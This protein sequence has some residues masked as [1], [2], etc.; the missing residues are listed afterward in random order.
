MLPRQAVLLPRVVDELRQRVREQPIDGRGDA[1][2][3]ALVAPPP[4]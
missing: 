4:R 1:D 3:L 2:P